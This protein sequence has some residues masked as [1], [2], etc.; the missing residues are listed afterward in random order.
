MS[1]RLTKFSLLAATM[2]AGI[3]LTSTGCERGDGNV[4]NEAT[5]MDK[6]AY[7]EM[8]RKNQEQMSGLSENAGR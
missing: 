7:R 4:A 3:L 8:V 2:L 1:E 5:E 6:E